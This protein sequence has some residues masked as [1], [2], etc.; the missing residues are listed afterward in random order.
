L[1]DHV[2]CPICTSAKARPFRRIEG[3]DYFE[4]K[5]CL[6][7]FLDPDVLSRLDEGQTLVT[8][9][10]SY[11]RMELA[12]AQERS[13]GSSLARVAEAFLYC[14][15]P[16]KRFIDIGTGPGYLLD[17]LAIHL[18]HAADTFYGVEAFPPKE[19]SAHKNYLKGALGDLPLKFDGGSCI[20][21]IE[22]L[23]PRMAARLIAE[24]ARV[25]EPNAFYLFNSGLPAYVKSENPD[26]LD[27]LVRGHVASYS[28]DAVQAMARPCGFVVHAIQG[29]GWAYGLEYLG[30]DAKAATPDRDVTHRIWSPCPE[31]VSTLKDPATGSLMYIL[32]IETA[33]AYRVP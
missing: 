33:R 11:W 7:L 13:F 4:C 19:H 25:S 26:Y 10:E 9:D 14:R 31:N 5:S 23:T 2:H 21:V 20:E 30:S 17:A 24:L 8:Y 29:K 18:P 27:P 15:R 32:G 16:I 22:H 28:L 1:R 3:Y 12:A 6:S